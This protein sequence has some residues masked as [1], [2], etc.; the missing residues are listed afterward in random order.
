MT[1]FPFYACDF[2]F[3]GSSKNENISLSQKLHLRL[4]FFFKCWIQM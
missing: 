2:Y 4:I 3:N 1:V